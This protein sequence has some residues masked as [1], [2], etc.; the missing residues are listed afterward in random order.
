MLPVSVESKKERRKSE[1]LNEREKYK[2]RA[3]VR[4]R[5]RILWIDEGVRYIVL[6]GFWKMHF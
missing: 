1:A 6:S 2:Q 5:I 3:E 4:I